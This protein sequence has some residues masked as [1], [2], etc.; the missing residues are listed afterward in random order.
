MTAVPRGGR[1]VG[2]LLGRA[3]LAAV[4]LLG[5]ARCDWTSP[6][7][8]AESV[9]VE[10]FLHTGE[11]LPA[12]T[13]RQ[14]AP[15]SVSKEGVTD[16]ATGA[17]VVLTYN[18]RRVAYQE[19][20]AQPG[21]YEPLV[22]DTVAPGVPWALTVR[23]QG[24]T[25]R[26]R[27]R[28]PRP[29]SLRDVCVNVPAAPVQAI[30]VDS[31]RRD[32]LDI[33]A[34]LDY[35]FPIDVRVRWTSPPDIAIGDTAAWVRAQVRPNASPFPSE[36][37]EFFLEPA[38][39]QQE[40]TYVR[41]DSGR[42]WQGVYA[43]PVDSSDEDLLPTHDVTAALVR[44]DTAFAEFAQSRTDP[45][46]REPISNVEGGLGIATAVSVDSAVVEEVTTPGQTRC[47]SP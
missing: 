15:L 45:D 34:T 16:A 5:L 23:W 39:I 12:I 4:L 19:R 38:A 17:E 10:A 18:G 43:V 32:S 6:P 47:V 13:L 22:S 29:I 42:Q 35:I 3:L 41:T 26:A 20:S 24:T 8:E 30:R 9:V 27:G 40:H 31:L 7:A 1:G 33:P 44:G 21:R 46:R 37:V 36:I 11:P 14:T 25:A 28:T 2:L